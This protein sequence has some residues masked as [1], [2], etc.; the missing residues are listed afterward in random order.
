MKRVHSRTFD[1]ND[2]L[3]NNLA[4]PRNRLKEKALLDNIRL[5]TLAVLQKG[6]NKLK[7]PTQEIQ[8]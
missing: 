1:S 5:V 2:N 3:I 8:E 7:R 6:N 4:R